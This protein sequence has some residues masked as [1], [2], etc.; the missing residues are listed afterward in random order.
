MWASTVAPVGGIGWIL[1]AAVTFAALGFVVRG[2]RARVRSIEVERRF[3]GL[4][5]A[6][7]VPTLIVDESGTIIDA[8]PAA[9][10][11]LAPDGVRLTGRSVDALIPFRYRPDHMRLRASF[12]T[13]PT[14]RAMSVGRIV[15]ALRTDGHELPVEITLSPVPF[16]AQR[17]VLVTLI[18]LTGRAQT[19]RE[20]RMRTEELQRSNAALERFAWSASHDLQE[21]LRM[22][23]S[24]SQLLARRYADALDDDGRQM[25]AFT[26]DGAS[27]MQRLINELLMY[28]RATQG[29]KP[30]VVTDTLAQWH[31][32]I[33]LLAS[34]IAAV[35]ADV[36]LD[37]ELPT[38]V[39][40]PVEVRQVFQNLV[41]NALKYR[42][43]GPTV[44]RAG[45][46]GHHDGLAR[47]YVTDNGIGI[48]PRHQE[49]IFEAFQRLGTR[50]SGTGIG[51]ALCKTVVVSHG[52]DI[53]VDSAPGDGATFWFTL[54]MAG[55]PTAG[56]PMA[57]DG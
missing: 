5:T 43:D 17:A 34:E 30:H 37:T 27:R 44:I 42:S 29:D 1:C 53:G 51:L 8:N 25:V 14:A 45:C 6:S 10:A 47:F 26:V 54:P 16:G 19:E 41:G 32:A 21:P 40:D 28:A 46:S 50:E 18:D 9:D 11:L 31:A 55:L 4:F 56:P 57:N 38:V 23:A 52:G 48:E 35:G 36:A 39:A 7:G 2:H 3:H 24:Y 15:S 12:W 13:E 22:I 49:K 20:L 33:D